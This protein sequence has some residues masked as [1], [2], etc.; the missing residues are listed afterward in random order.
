[1]TLKYHKTSVPAVG[2]TVVKVNYS[3]QGDYVTFKFASGKI[4]GAPIAKTYTKEEIKQ[5][6]IRHIKQS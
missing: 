5:I 6:I 3:L 4:I 1:M 2:D